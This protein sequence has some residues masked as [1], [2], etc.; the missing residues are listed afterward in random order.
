MQEFND[1]ARVGALLQWDHETYMSHRGA[2]ARA[3]QQ[4]TMRVIRHERLVDDR[5]G[6]QLDELAESDLDLYRAAMVRNLVL[7]VRGA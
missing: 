7:R 3:R 1:L 6:E 2:E 4:A 5:L